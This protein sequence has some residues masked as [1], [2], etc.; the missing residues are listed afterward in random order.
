MLETMPNC[1]QKMAEKSMT[2]AVA[3]TEAIKKIM[4]G[5]LKLVSIAKMEEKKPKPRKTV[6][7]LKVINK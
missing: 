1:P 2:S 5:N 4:I 3:Y 6:R 7:Q